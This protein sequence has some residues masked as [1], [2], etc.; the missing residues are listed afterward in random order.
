[1][2]TKIFSYY[3]RYYTIDIIERM[4]FGHLGGS[5][6]IAEILSV[7]YNEVMQIKPDDPKWHLRDYFVLSKG[8]GG[9]ALYA[10]LALKGF[11]PKEELAT[12]NKPGTKLPSHPDQKTIPGVDATT[13]SLGMGLSVA[14]G[15]ALGVRILNK[16]QYVY[17]IV[18]DGELQEGQ[19][20][21]AIQNAAHEKLSQV[22]VFVD[23]NMFQVDGNIKNICTPFNLKDKFSSFGWNVLEIHGHD[24]EEIRMAIKQAKNCSNKPT[25]VIAHTIKGRGMA[26]FE[27]G[28]VPH[29]IPFLSEVLL[30]DIRTEKK[31]LEALINEAGYEL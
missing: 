25:A 22:I 27:K 31:N 9:P 13:G 14:I 26:S 30:S 1:M 8:H 28:N 23:N 11:F 12:V 15:I 2:D 7:L 10:A 19:C 4:G 29:N 16:N 17:S 21:E 20:W 5:L 24:I 6:S 18:G 3:V